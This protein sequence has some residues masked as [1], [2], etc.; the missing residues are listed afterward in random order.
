MIIPCPQCGPRDLREFSIKGD[1]T[2]LDRPSTDA[3]PEAW[4]DYL[5]NR[6][7]LAGPVCELW[8]HAQGCGAWLVV[9]R[10]T[11]THEITGATLAREEVQNAD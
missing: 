8:H 5:H 7:N 11:V 1:V 2:Y 3:P 6:D 4:D 10:N 9:A